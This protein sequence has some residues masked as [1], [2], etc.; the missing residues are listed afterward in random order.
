LAFYISLKVKVF[1]M[2]AE[3]LEKKPLSLWPHQADLAASALASNCHAMFADPGVGKTAAT[4]TVLRHIY[5]RYQKLISTLILCPPIVRRNWL[6]EFGMF[7]KITPDKIIVLEGSE[8][9]R[10]KTLQEQLLFMGAFVPKIVIT[11]YESLLME[12]IFGL[13]ELWGPKILICDE[14]HR[15]KSITAKR[16][17]QAIK[18]ADR[19]DFRYILTGTPILNSSMDLFSQYRILDRGETFGT[20]FYE[21][22]HRYFVDKNAWMNR[23]K[24]FPNWRPRP[25]TEKELATK[26]ASKSTVIRKEKCLTLPPLV[27]K[28]IYID[29]SS[30]QQKHYSQLKKDFITFL[31]EQACTAQLAITKALRLQQL[32]SGHLPFGEGNDKKIHH[33]KKTPRIQAFKDLAQEICGAG[34]KLLTWCAFTENYADIAEACTEI[35]LGFT[36]ATGEESS[37]GKDAAIDEFRTN[38]DCKVLIGNAAA[39]GVGVNLQEASYSIFYSRNFNLEHQLQAQARNYRAGSERHASVTQLEF[40]AKD[41]I[42]EV[43][44]EALENKFG[45]GQKLLDEFRARL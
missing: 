8:K 33:F 34:H 39:I 43:V 7:S 16:T 19:A 17:K 26:I 22:R 4:I 45:I 40:V 5:A 10:Y 23:Q 32:I 13:F 15:C 38:P 6:Q 20:N 1:L 12:S 42:D 36:K 29:L 27:I 3:K 44:A 41:T 31:G 9:Q 35:G 18:L 14:S 24:H 25:D 2:I 11:N 28:K 30:E 21:F 37:K